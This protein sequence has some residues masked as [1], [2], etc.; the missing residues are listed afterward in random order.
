MT[1]IGL[2]LKDEDIHQ[3]D[4]Y[5]GHGGTQGVAEEKNVGAGRASRRWVED[6]LH[7]FPAVIDPGPR[8]V[9]AFKFLFL[10]AYSVLSLLHTAWIKAWLEVAFVR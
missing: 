1:Q 2:D 4:D 8:H 3:A 10:L 9:L 6:A 5:A 7:P